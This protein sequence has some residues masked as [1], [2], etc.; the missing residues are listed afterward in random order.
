VQ[1]AADSRDEREANS[2]EQLARFFPELRRV[3]LAAF[4]SPLRSGAGTLREPV[5]VE[6]AGARTA[7]FSSSL[8]FEFED[9]VRLESDDHPAF[10]A[11]VIAVQYRDGRTVVA[12]NLLQSQESWVNRL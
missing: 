1:T 2:A 5:L 12:V 4:V 9:R 10:D 11:R 8:P 3:R 7:I 6:F